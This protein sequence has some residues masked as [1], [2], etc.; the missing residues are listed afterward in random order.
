LWAATA[1]AVAGCA[2]GLAP[3]APAPDP[4]DTQRDS[5][6]ALARVYT[7]R[8]PGIGTFASHTWFVVRHAGDSDFHRWEV[9]LWG[10]GT[11]DF[12]WEDLFAPEA[13]LGIPPVEILAELTGEPAEQFADYLEAASANYPC[14]HFYRFAAGPN[15]N[16]YTRW[17]LDGFGWDVSLPES[18]V[19]QDVAADCP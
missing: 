18:A 17:V 14:Q 9:W 6:Q 16:S 5:T 15:S 11:Y 13:D 7:A 2:G 3:S 12:V 10:G 19:G 8:I 1:L 4:S